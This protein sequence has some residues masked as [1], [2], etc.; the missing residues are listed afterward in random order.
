M[1]DIPRPH[2]EA[3]SWLRLHFS[4]IAATRRGAAGLGTAGLDRRAPIRYT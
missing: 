1:A 4:D 2:P 3:F